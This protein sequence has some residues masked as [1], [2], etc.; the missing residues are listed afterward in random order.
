[1][2]VP[3]ARRWGKPT[4][5]SILFKMFFHSCQ[6]VAWW[7][8]LLASSE[9]QRQ[10][11]CRGT[12]TTTTT[13]TYPQFLLA[14]STLATEASS[15]LSMNKSHS[16]MCSR[17]VLWYV[18]RSIASFSDRLVAYYFL[19]PVLMLSWI[20]DY[21]WLGRAVGQC[22]WSKRK[23]WGFLS[24]SEAVLPMTLRW[25]LWAL[26]LVLGVWR[27]RMVDLSQTCWGWLAQHLDYQHWQ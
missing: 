14:Y 16:G 4:Q 19:C 20:T 18:S 11:Y 5:F 25:W 24:I 1:M 6:P 8:L 13:T 3:V 12:H 22:W 9:S 23:R 15:E 17:P 27:N 21:C 26:Q 2:L 10:A 7:D